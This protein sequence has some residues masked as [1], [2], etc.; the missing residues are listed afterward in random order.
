MGLSISIWPCSYSFITQIAVMN[1]DIEQAGKAVF[2]ST[3]TF[4]SLSAKPKHLVV[5]VPAISL[6]AQLIPGN[7]FLMVSKSFMVDNPIKSLSSNAFIVPNCK[8][9]K[10]GR[11][12]TKKLYWRKMSVR[13]PDPLIES[14]SSRCSQLYKLPR[15]RLILLGFPGF[16]ASQ[17][18]A[19]NHR[20]SSLVATFCLHSF[21]VRSENSTVL[22]H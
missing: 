21:A 1:F 6:Y 10:Y 14:Q 19:K 8:L 3:G 17:L 20:F 9:I 22:C 18:F 5:T 13:T 2:S 15:N 7:L 12:V 4:A 16:I 11:Q